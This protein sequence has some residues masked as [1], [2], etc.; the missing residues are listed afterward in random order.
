MLFEKVYQELMNYYML[1]EGKFRESPNILKLGDYPMFSV[2]MDSHSER[3]HERITNYSNNETIF[4]KAFEIA[5]HD[6]TKMGLPSMHVNVVFRYT[7]RAFGIAHGIPDSS[8]TYRRKSK[9]I[10]LSVRF[11]DN[12]SNPIIETLHYSF[13]TLVST[14]VHEWAH[15]WMFNNGEAFRNAIKQYHEALVHSN[16]DKIPYD[17]GNTQEIFSKFYNFISDHLDGLRSIYEK[18]PSR[19]TLS[20]ISRRVK[21][22]LTDAFNAYRYASQVDT[23]FIDQYVDR[24]SDYIYHNITR[25]DIIIPY[26]KSLNLEKVFENKIKNETQNIIVKREDILEQLSDMINFTGA[27]GLTTPDEAWATALEKFNI[28]H[29]YHKKRIRELMQINEPRKKP[30]SRM[31]RHINKKL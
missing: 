1:N 20:D 16:I 28:L 21:Y 3:L 9:S 29:P 8:R 10:S 6:I 11:I 31:Q 2:F 26:I 25:M 13:S 23:D 30:N 12:L 4:K 27:Y 7:P 19:L 17:Y 14:I 22:G 15:I 5:R 18:K 24:I